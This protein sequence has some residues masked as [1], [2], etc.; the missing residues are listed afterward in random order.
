MDRAE[1]M[2]SVTAAVAAA[3]RR[4]RADLDRR[5]AGPVLR[6]STRVVP[7][8]QVAPRLPTAAQAPMASRWDKAVRGPAERSEPDNEIE[9]ASHRTRPLDMY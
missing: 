8:E 4:V 5:M 3:G 6:A 7:P 1:I 2:G 9:Q